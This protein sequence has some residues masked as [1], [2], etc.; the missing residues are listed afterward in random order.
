[1]KLLITFLLLFFLSNNSISQIKNNSQKNIPD[2]VNMAAI[3]LIEDWGF[4]AL[5]P[6]GQWGQS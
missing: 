4:L 1:M 5:V 6:N 3:L 2:S